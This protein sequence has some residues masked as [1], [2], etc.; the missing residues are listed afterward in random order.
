MMADPEDT[1]VQR[2]SAAGLPPTGPPGSTT[3]ALDQATDDAVVTVASPQEEL[4]RSIIRSKVQP[5]PVRA[6]T[7]ERPRLLQWLGGHSAERLMLINAEA[8]YGKTTLLAD[9]ARRSTVRCIWYRLDATDRDWVTFISYVIAAIREVQPEFGEATAGLLAQLAVTTLPLDVVLDSL[10]SELPTIGHAPTLFL[11]DDFHLVDDAP[12]VH[13]ILGRFFE[14]APQ[15]LGFVLASRVAPS[16]RVARLAAHGQVARIDTDDLRFSSEETADLFAVAYQLPLEPDLVDEIDARAEGWA[17][18]LQ[19]VYSSIRE[20]RPS[21]ARAFI[22]SLSGAEGALYD[23][24]AEEVLAGLSA[25]LQRVLVRASLLERVVP[26]YVMAILSAEPDPPTAQHLAALL[27]DADGLGLMGRRA[28]GGSTRRFHPLLREFLRRQL[29]WT[30]EPA[31]RRQMHLRVASTAEGLSDWLVACHHYIDGGDP[32]AS[33]TVLG[34]WAATAV[35]SGALGAAMA[36]V[37]RS[38]MTEVPAAV[39]V[40]EARYLISIGAIQEATEILGRLAS[41]PI[42]PRDAALVRLARVLAAFRTGQRDVMTESLNAI[43]ADESLSVGLR[44]IARAWELVLLTGIGD[45][46]EPA[47]SFFAEVGARQAANGDIHFAAISFHNAAVYAISRGDYLGAIEFGDQA[48]AYFHQM[49]ET[50]VEAISTRAHIATAAWEL[51][52]RERAMEETDAVRATSHADADAYA[53]CAWSA[54]IRGEQG[55]AIEFLQKAHA[56]LGRAPGDIGVRGFVDRCEVVIGTTLGQP[57]SVDLDDDVA[58]L[59]PEPDF[60]ARNCLVRACWECPRDPKRAWHTVARGTALA[61]AQG[62]NRYEPRLAVVGAAVAGDGPALLAS[63][64]RAAASGNLALL[65]LAD[66]I[67]STLHHLPRI[68]KSVKDSFEQWPA[69]W[70]P[71]LRRQMGLGNV[72]SA[73]AAAR[74]LSEI[75]S[76]SD[77]S[78]LVAFERSY[79]RAPRHRSLSRALIRRASPTLHLHD[80]GRSTITVGSYGLDLAQTRRKAASLLMLLTT[81]PGQTATREQVIEALWPDMDP[82]AAMNSLNQ[83]LYFLRRDIDPWYNDLTS[84]DYVVNESD[85]I[86]IDPELTSIASVTFLARTTSSLAE[87]ELESIRCSAL[88]AEYRGRFSPEFEYEE[89]A[90]GWR[91]RLHSAFLMLVQRRLRD[92]TEAGDHTG[93]VEVL[94]K[95][96]AVDP[97]ALELEVELVRSL[98]A[99]GADAAATHQYGH[100][101]RAFR[102]DLG[103]DPPP[104]DSLAPNQ[105]K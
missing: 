11:L 79:I 104:F 16:I 73:H 69:R 93:A 49:D 62:A 84:A 68:P 29:E 39:R 59:G 10:I 97:E 27:D 12:D 76:L 3:P 26:N 34:E 50:P 77:A 55:G 74:V 58:M 61:I 23:Y 36:L 60:V 41:D 18:S 43:R 80:L 8:G 98:R 47:G 54:A 45:P 101:A 85:L 9:F 88:I 4:A 92:L 24:L 105:P 103:A 6:A 13:A 25:P 95:A 7:L 96:L 67:A 22:N 19:L 64:E 30:S 40:I 89:W 2:L 81:K 15:S 14:R 5:P 87:R 100:L 65:E 48:L 21:E 75:G 35:G 66:L 33:M 46:I 28:A 20:R 70:L 90:I 44:D 94:M 32:I 1:S 56:A 51:G 83:T 17:A 37:A 72:P 86:W 82:S 38:G 102:G 91:E 42:R 53:E 31:E 52:Y 71:A 99:Q 63:L 78:R 57:V